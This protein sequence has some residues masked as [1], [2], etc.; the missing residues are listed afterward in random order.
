MPKPPSLDIEKSSVWLLANNTTYEKN[1]A[2]VVD[3]IAKFV[4]HPGYNGTHAAESGFLLLYTLQ[5][6]GVLSYGDKSFLLQPGQAVYLDRTQPHAF[7][8][9]GNNNWH[10]NWM[11]LDGANCAYYFDALYPRGFNPINCNLD[12]MEQAFTT[13]LTD[14]EIP[15]R[16][17]YIQHSNAVSQMLQHL[18]ELQCEQNGEELPHIEAIQSTIAYIREN[19]SKAIEV[20]ELADM[21]GLSKYYYIKIFNEVTHTTPYEYLLRQ[22]INESKRLLRTTTY[23]AAEIAFMVGFADE[24]N[25][26]RTFKRFTNTTPLRYRKSV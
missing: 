8:A 1:L 10:F 5:G 20:G 16:A 17:R 26:S 22:R 23:K 9:K 6:E 13:V 12:I 11:Y 19:Y 18:F 15:S 24:C 25:F 3:E 2:F 21:A 4:T 14:F 7:T